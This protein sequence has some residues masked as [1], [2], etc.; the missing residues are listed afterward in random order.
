MDIHSVKLEQAL[1]V[2]GDLLTDRGHYYEVVAIGGGGLLLLGQIERPTKDL[3]LIALVEEDQLVSATPLPL[4][5]LQ[6]AEDVGRAL[7][8]G[9]GWL[10]VGPAVLLETGLPEGFQQRMQT[11]YYEGLTIHL[12]GRFDQICFKLYAAVD[13]GPDSKHFADLKHL[14]PSREELQTARCWCV[15]QD[16]SEPFSI[17]LNHAMNILGGDNEHS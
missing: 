3:D 8:L 17:E 4:G 13:Q 14:N 16:T 5:L 1:A 11:R 7:D 12:A 9:E 6:A 10:N 2:L 15:T